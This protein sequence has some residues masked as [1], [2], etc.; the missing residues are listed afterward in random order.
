MAETPG[1]RGSEEGTQ[2]WFKRPQGSEVS[3]APRFESFENRPLP[4][5]DDLGVS[6]MHITQATPV[7]T[8][9]ETQ[10]SNYRALVKRANDVFGSAELATRWLSS[11][12]PLLEGRIPLQILGKENYSCEAIAKYLEPIFRRIEFGIPG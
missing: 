11:P 12:N 9:L 5:E 1:E 10:L 7:D 3:K 2:R 8:P 6:V 4:N